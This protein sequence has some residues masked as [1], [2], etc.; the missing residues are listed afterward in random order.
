MKMNKIASFIVLLLMIFFVACESKTGSKSYK[1][2]NP[3]LQQVVMIEVLQTNSYTYLKY[4]DGEAVNWG[5]IPRRDDIIEGNTYYFDN[6]ME[7]KNF[8]SKE[9][10]STFDKIYFI[11]SISDQPYSKVN[12]MTQGRKGSP[13][14][15]NMEVEKIEPVEGSITIKELFKDKFGYEGKTIKLHGLVVKYTGSVMGK[16]WVHIQDGTRNGDKLDITITTKDIVEN[17]DIVTFEGI[18]VLDKDFGHGYAY[19]VIIEEAKLL[20]RKSETKMY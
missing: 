16:N 15:G 2:N 9:L 13:N 10:D 12:T 7:M 14:V 1:E 8:T 17:G 20:D 4:D 6:F 11:E 3:N 18:V 5:A 19:D